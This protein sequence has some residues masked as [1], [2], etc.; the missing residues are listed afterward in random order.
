MAFF[1]AWRKTLGFA[2]FCL[3]AAGCGGNE[4]GTNIDEVE[5]DPT[6]D[7]D[8]PVPGMT[9]DAGAGKVDASK[10]PAPTPPSG[11]KSDASVTPAKADA[12]ISVTPPRTDAGTSMDGGNPLEGLPDLG[13]LFPTPADGGTKPGTTT[14]SGTCDDK[15]PHGCFTPATGNPMGCPKNSPEIPLGL[16]SL[17]MWD[18]CNGGAVGAGASCSYTGPGGETASCLC[19]TGVHWL[20]VYL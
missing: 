1:P 15:T 3:W 5:E 8:D 12:G 19:D 18:L 10:P 11:T 7:D 20:C 2:L 16:P 13:E 14:G 9:K 6:D 4:T 17:D